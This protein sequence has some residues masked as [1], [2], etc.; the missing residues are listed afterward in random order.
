[1]APGTELREERVPLQ[2][3][4]HIL[5]VHK[6]RLVCQRLAP[7]KNANRAVN[8]TTLFPIKQEWLFPANYILHT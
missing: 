2:A 8:R 1:M 6:L 5:L 4:H 3:V 7:N